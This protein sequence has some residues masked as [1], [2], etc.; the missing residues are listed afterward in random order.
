[1]SLEDAF[2]FFKVEGSVQCSV[3]GATEKPGLLKFLPGW[4]MDFLQTCNSQSASW[5]QANYRPAS[6]PGCQ[7]STTPG[8]SSASASD[9]FLGSRLAFGGP[10]TNKR[11]KA[12]QPARSPVAMVPAPVLASVP[13]PQ[14]TPA[15]RVGGPADSSPFT[16]G[17]PA[18]SSPFTVRGPADSSPF[19]DG[20]PAD[21]SP[22]SVRGKVIFY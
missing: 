16:D 22:F 3:R 7:P 8:L 12:R 11:R 18:D 6:T 2:F 14:P 1:M 21:S 4:I 13:A 9:S 10:R 5:K 15:P 19:T 17:G 20:G